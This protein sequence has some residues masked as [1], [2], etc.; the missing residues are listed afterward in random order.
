M[1]EALL[2]GIAIGFVLALSVGPVIFTV[3]KQ[4]INNGKKGGFSFIAGVWFS[5]VFLVVLTNAFTELA[6]GLMA[7]K[8]IIGVAGSVFLMSMGLYYIFFKKSHIRPEDK[9][10]QPFRKRDVAKIFLSG[11][12]INTLNPA[13]IA[14]WLASA[15]GFAISYTLRQRI[16]IF[17]T[18]IIIN[19]LADIAKVTLAGRIRNRLT[20]RNIN[21]I[22]RISG[23]I[24]FI[25]GIALFWG[26]IFLSEK[27]K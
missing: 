1:I 4:S 7:H 3:I 27:M 25:F 5:D 26:A 18:C 23:S 8:K 13:V 12:F 20:D 14:F 17:T 15:T 6:T 22:N 10:D 2:Q 9:E 24:L 16:I 21:L 19:I 11:F